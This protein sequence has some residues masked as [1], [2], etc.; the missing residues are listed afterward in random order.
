[1]EEKREGREGKGREEIMEE[2]ERRGWNLEDRIS[3]G[4]KGW[5]G[6]SKKTRS[7]VI[8]STIL[9]FL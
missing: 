7:I 1:M 4:T 3:I 9:I 2:K 6:Y 8:P 5:D